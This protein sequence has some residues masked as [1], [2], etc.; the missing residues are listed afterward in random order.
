MQATIGK[1]YASRN[2]L[3]K[4]DASRNL[5]DRLLQGGLVTAFGEGGGQAV[6]AQQFGQQAPE[7]RPQQVAPLREHRVQ[8]GA[9]PLQPIGLHGQRHLRRRGGDAQLAEQAREA[10]IGA[11]VEHQEAGV[12]AVAA[13]LQREVHGAGVAAAA[14]LCLEQRERDA[15]AQRVAG[16][17]PGDAAADHRHPRAGHRHARPHGQEKRAPCSTVPSVIKKTAQR[18]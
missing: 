13:A 7:V 12:H 6:E 1:K 9:A 10:R 4:A 16:A 8:R 3:P 11:L 15:P 14:A 5:A 17:Q 18:P 2:S